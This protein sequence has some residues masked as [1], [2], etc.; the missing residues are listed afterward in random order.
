MENI[1]DNDELLFADDD[2][3]NN[4]NEY[5]NYNILIVDDKNSTWD[6]NFSS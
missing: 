5:L 4:N 2:L 1:I 6:D 3:D